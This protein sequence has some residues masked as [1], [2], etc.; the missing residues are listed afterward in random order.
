LATEQRHLAQIEQ[1]VA[2]CENRLRR[3]EKLVAR[4]HEYG[5]D[6]ATAK[7]ML[8]DLRRLCGE[9]AKLRTNIRSAML[10]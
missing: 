7:Q 8:V 9:L 4:L 2:D 1:R 3:Q 6:L 10:H 5:C